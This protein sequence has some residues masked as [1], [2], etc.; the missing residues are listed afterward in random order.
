MEVEIMCP[1][2]KAMFEVELEVSTVFE[3]DGDNCKIPVKCECG[4][5]GYIKVELNW[6]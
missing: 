4:S 3:M 5:S 1:I 2:C 6:N